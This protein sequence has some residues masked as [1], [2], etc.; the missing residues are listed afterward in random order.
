MHI[1][2]FNIGDFS[3]ATERFKPVHLGIFLRLLMEYYKS[4]KALTDDATE[5]EW[6]AGVETKSERDAL[7]LVLRRCFV[8]DAARKVWVQKRVEREIQKFELAGLQKRHANVCKYWAKTNPSSKCPT[9]EEFL[10]DPSKYHDETTHRVRTLSVSPPHGVRTEHSRNPSNY[11]T[12]S[13]TENSKQKTV[14]RQQ[15]GTAD[16]SAPSGVVEDDLD[17]CN[18]A[19]LAESQDS[20]AEKKEEQ[21]GADQHEWLDVGGGEARRAINTALGRHPSRAFTGAELHAIGTYAQQNGG[22]ISTAQFQILERYLGAS[23]RYDSRDIAALDAVPEGSLLRKR[24]RYAS[25]VIEDL[26]NQLDYALAWALERQKKEKVAPL[27]PCPVADYRPFAR[28]TIGWTLAPDDQTPWEALSDTLRRDWL[29]H[30]D[31]EQRK[32]NSQTVA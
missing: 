16:A 14:T 25:N 20:A 10:A 32:Q 22:K 27:P 28:E 2:P 17:P 19:P 29:R 18:S 3:Q 12:E 21:G 1:I 7:M 9:L 26:P 30:W 15:G 8:H 31:C 5:I 11:K 13:Y 23:P 4:E 24:K 6:I